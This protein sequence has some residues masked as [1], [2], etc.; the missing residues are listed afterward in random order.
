[1]TL[2]NP[3]AVRQ[4]ASR[5]EAEDAVSV[6]RRLRAL[7]HI[8]GLLPSIREEGALLREVVGALATY[9]ERPRQVRMFLADADGEATLGYALLGRRSG[10]RKTSRHD[11]ASA[12]MPAVSIGVTTP[13]STSA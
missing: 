9:F 8:S 4:R 7:S 3:I 11:G 12:S 6:L 2:V 13:G 1:M 10:A 5:A